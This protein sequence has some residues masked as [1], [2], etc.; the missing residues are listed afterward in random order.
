MDLLERSYVRSLLARHGRN[1][2]AAA[3]EAG[4]NRTYLHRLIR[5]HDL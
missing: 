5:K 2:T 3:K 1:V 4:L